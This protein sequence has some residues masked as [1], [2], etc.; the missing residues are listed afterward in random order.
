MLMPARRACHHNR[1]KKIDLICE[2]ER[3]GVV[4]EEEPVPTRDL[5]RTAYWRFSVRKP[6]QLPPELAKEYR[7]LGELRW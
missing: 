5:S 3:R 6:N 7:R 2:L 1:G 4:R